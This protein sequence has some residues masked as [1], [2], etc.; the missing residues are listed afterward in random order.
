MDGDTCG[1]KH[2]QMI[3]IEAL[4]IFLQMRNKSWLQGEYT[5]YTVFPWHISIANY[6]F[7]P[8]I[9]GYSNLESWKWI[10]HTLDFEPGLHNFL[11]FSRLIKVF[12]IFL[13]SGSFLRPG[14]GI[15]LEDKQKIKIGLYFW[16]KIYK[17]KRLIKAQLMRLVAIKLKLAS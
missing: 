7:S 15:S 11:S 8:S 1:L 13:F 2:F 3:S 5:I 16:L 12:H 10:E 6:L 4:R 14:N 9:V 17:V